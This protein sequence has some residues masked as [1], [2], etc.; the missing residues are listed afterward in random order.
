M[1]FQREAMKLG[2]FSLSALDLFGFKLDDGSALRTDKMVMMIIARFITSQAIIEMPFF[3][4]PRLD[5]KLHGPIDGGVPDP[6]ALIDDDPMKFFARGV[7]A[8]V[9]KGIENDFPLA[10]SLELILF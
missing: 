5:Q 9:K 1:F 4:Q 2:N 10:G 6:G 8:L 7:P 3:G